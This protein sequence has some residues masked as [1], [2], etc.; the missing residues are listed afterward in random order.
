MCGMYLKADVVLAQFIIW[1][2]A[3]ETHALLKL[4][5]GENNFRESLHIVVYWLLIDRGL[6]RYEKLT[7]FSDKVSAEKIE[8]RHA[9]F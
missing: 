6:L 1:V 4:S 2:L 5:R 3:F 8:L 7:V 9:E